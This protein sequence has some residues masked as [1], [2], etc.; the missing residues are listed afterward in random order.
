MV[1]GTRGAGIARRLGLPMDNAVRGLPGQGWRAAVD[2][3]VRQPCVPGAAKVVEA[4]ASVPRKPTVGMAGVSSLHG[5]APHR[6]LTF[7]D[8][9]GSDKYVVLCEQEG[10]IGRAK[11]INLFSNFIWSLDGRRSRLDTSTLF[12]PRE[13]PSAL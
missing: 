13:G 11:A 2:T 4:S 3:I 10:G 9:G 8:L 12:T 1:V 5:V 6:V 7:S